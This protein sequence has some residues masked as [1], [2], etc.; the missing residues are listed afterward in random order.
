[1]VAV[2]LAKTRRTSSDACE[3]RFSV[4]DTGIGVDASR[5]DLLFRSFSQADGS[6]TRKYGGTG[7]GLAISRQLVKMMGGT[8]GLHSEPGRGSCF[9]FTVTTA[10]VHDDREALPAARSTP[11]RRLNARVLVA[12]D[13]IVNQAVV[14]AMLSGMG[15][16][17]QLASNGHEAVAAANTGRFDMILMDCHMPA[18]DGFEATRVLRRLEAERHSMRTP[19]IALTANAMAGA[20]ERCLAAGMDDYLAKPFKLDQLWSVMTPWMK[21]EAAPG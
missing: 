10:A 19:I 8:I 20:R 12:E 3:L 18:M 11:L 16:E 6:T 2:E 13:N 21:A 17:V 9:H 5:K 7:L 15:C 14:L 4:T 1:V